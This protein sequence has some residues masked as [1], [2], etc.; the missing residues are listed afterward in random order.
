MLGTSF[1]NTRFFLIVVSFWNYPRKRFLQKD[2]LIVLQIDCQ[3]LLDLN[4]KQINLCKSHL[5]I[6]F[7]IPFQRYHAFHSNFF[8]RDFLR[9][10]GIH[11]QFLVVLLPAFPHKF[12]LATLPFHFPLLNLLPFLRRCLPKDFHFH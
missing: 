6:H 1:P 8:A 4:L 11:L 9:Q 5:K 10:Q 12:P 3:L 7:A 2:A